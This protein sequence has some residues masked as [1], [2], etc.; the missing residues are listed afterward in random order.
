[1]VS[2]NISILECGIQFSPSTFNNIPTSHSFIYNQA[3]LFGK[4]WYR[5][6][7]KSDSCLKDAIC[8]YDDEWNKNYPD[9]LFHLIFRLE[10]TTDQQV[11][12]NKSDKR[13]KI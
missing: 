7:F 3:V 1:M 2:K 9:N 10:D 5:N 11:D 8:A 6:F 13:R 4:T 12:R